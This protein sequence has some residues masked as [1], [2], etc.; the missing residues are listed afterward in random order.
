MNWNDY[1]R[2][3]EI[4]AL[5]RGMDPPLVA[6]YLAYAD[7]LV[8]S[9]LPIIY[10]DAHLSGLLGFAE[11]A[12]KESLRRPND[13]YLSYSIPKRSG[14]FRRIDQPVSSL[15]SIHTWILRNILDRCSAHPAATAFIRG[16]SI[17]DNAAKHVN[18]VAVLTLDVAAFF[19]SIRERDVRVVF[20]RLGY[21]PSV[22]D[23]LIRSTTLNG[24]L[25]QGAP[26]SPSLSNLVMLDCDRSLTEF[27]EQNQLAFT[28]YADDFS[29]SGNYSSRAW[30]GRTIREVRS[31]IQ[32]V[33]LRLNESKTRL[34]LGH[35]RQEVTGIV[36]NTRMNVRRS[37][38]RELRKNVYFAAKYG[39]AGAAA[40]PDPF[41]RNPAEHIRGVAEF[42]RFVG[43]N[44]RDALAAIRLLGRVRF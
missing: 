42:V 9:G 36:V 32:R 33:G 16:R 24:G 41:G 27:A 21:A 38:R 22:V 35:Q 2:L 19:D 44:D 40:R 18:R 12:L 7:R 5:N 31:Q 43:P 20:S 30:V 15:K 13:L 11:A 23:L 10:D 34:M 26:T 8:R 3:F 29:F 6:A 28:R 4:E 17:M 25:P 39:V 37:V 1:Q 14:G